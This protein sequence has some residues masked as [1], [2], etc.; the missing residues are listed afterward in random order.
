MIQKENEKIDKYLYNHREQEK[1]W[2]K[3]VTSI[4]IAGVGLGKGS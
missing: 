4:S 1:L 2:N 3:K